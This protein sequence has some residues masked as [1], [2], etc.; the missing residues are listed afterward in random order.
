[1][2]K[3]VDIVYCFLWKLCTI[4]TVLYLQIS[5]NIKGKVH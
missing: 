4:I 5:G 2:N 3:C 1:M